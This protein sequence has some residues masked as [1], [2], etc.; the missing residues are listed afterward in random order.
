LDF[1]DAVVILEDFEGTQLFSFFSTF[2]SGEQVFNVFFYGAVSFL[3]SFSYVLVNFVGDGYTFV[4]LSRQNNQ[5]PIPY[6]TVQLY[7]I[8]GFPIIM[9]PDRQ[10]DLGNFRLCDVLSRRL[11]DIKVSFLPV[12]DKRK[13]TGIKLNFWVGNP[14]F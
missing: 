9:K 12:N 8:N 11:S 7:M 4:S 3:G 5:T 13:A 1:G 10:T 2:V 14:Q 6:F